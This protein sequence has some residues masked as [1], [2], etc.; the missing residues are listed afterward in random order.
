MDK[1]PLV[2]AGAL[3]FNRKNRILFVKSNK[4]K[5]QYG[6]PAGKV[7]YGEK[8]I[9]GLKREIK[10]ETNLDVY[11]I[12]FL[13]RQEIINPKDFFKKSHFVSLNYICRA[14]NTNI[15]LNNEAQS[16][17]WVTAKNALKLGLNEPTRELIQ[18]YLKI[19]NKDKIIIKDL[20]IECIV[21]VR[22]RERKEKQ[23]IYVT[24]EI[25]TNTEKAAKSSNITDTIN[26]SSIIKNIKRLVTNKKY[27]L[28]ETMAE[29][30]AKMILRNKNTNEVKVLIKK[31]KAIGKGKYA[32]VEIERWQN[33]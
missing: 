25:Y 12:K 28:L 11:G 1:F 32:A 3:I 17:K 13:L 29:D 2:T 10:E 22:K 24:I 18:Y 14:K 23:K 15:E 26:Y 9:D 27:L 8:I 5:G 19:I 20:E 21:G 30:I 6:I 31:P 4:W 33:G 7:R 16:Y